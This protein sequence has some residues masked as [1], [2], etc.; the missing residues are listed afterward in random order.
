MTLFRRR[1][2]TNL[3]VFRCLTPDT[4]S[5]HIGTTLR[6]HNPARRLWP[7]FY[8][9]VNVTAVN[10]SAA[11]PQRSSRFPIYIVLDSLIPLTL[12]RYT[13]RRQVKEL[14]AVSVSPCAVPTSIGNRNFHQIQLSALDVVLIGIRTRPV[15]VRALIPVLCSSLSLALVSC[16]FFFSLPLSLS[17]HTDESSD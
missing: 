1:G 11:K 4:C 7:T 12:H 8:K 3:S 15:I 9:Y 16:K 13:P 2:N 5:G 10:K 14:G 17:L 6:E